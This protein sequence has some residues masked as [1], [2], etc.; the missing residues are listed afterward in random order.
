VDL[1]VAVEEGGPHGRHELAQVN[2]GPSDD[3]G[4]ERL[5]DHRLHGVEEEPDSDLLGQVE[6][7][8][9]ALAREPLVGPLGPDAGDAVQLVGRGAPVVAETG[10]EQACAGVEPGPHILDIAGA[11][12]SGV[13][14]QSQNAIEYGRHQ[15]VRIGLDTI[16]HIRQVSLGGIRH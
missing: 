14:R 10:E 3:V 7:G 6:A 8:A 11:T 2:P 16:G 9:H 1:V 15:A 4:P 13:S 12:R 5:V